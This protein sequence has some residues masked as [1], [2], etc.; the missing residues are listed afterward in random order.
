M[1]GLGPGPLT[2]SPPLNSALEKSTVHRRHPDPTVPG[3][4]FYV[5]VWRVRCKS[6]Q[7]GTTYASC[8]SHGISRE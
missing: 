8:E 5:M 2:P 4:L 1:G 3:P 6:V 7:L